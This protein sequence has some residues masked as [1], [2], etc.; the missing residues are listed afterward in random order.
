MNPKAILDIIEK[1]DRFLVACH[2][3]MEGDSLGSQLALASLLRKHGKQVITANGTAVPDSLKFLSGW[4][5]VII[6]PGT[7]DLAEVQCMVVVDCPHL[8]RIGP[9]YDALPPDV[10]I[11]N[12]DHH[13][14]NEQF[15]HVNWI[16]GCAAAVGEM[17]YDLF[18]ASGHPMDGD[19]ALAL[20][21][22]IMTDTGS[23]RFSNTT[24]G[25]LKR[26]AALLNYGIKPH[27]VYGHVYESHTQQ[28]LALLK[29]VLGNLQLT[30]NNQV[31]T[32]CV[33]LEMMER[34]GGRPESSDWFLDI[35]RSVGVV[36]A[37]ALLT[38]LDPGRIKISL[39]SKG[40]VDVNR[41]ACFFGGGGH[42]AAAGCT[43]EK[44]LAEAR[45]LLVEQIRRAVSEASPAEL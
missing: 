2:V 17:I 18:E 26:A 42:R 28:E 9:V 13:V 39:R 34:C 31:A 32:A 29:E 38:E 20:Y 8:K 33:T 37:T 11:V 30:D 27:E 10:F 22:S 6:D 4:P 25:T 36:R 7:T 1:Y 43:I 45:E 19:A 21:T 3:N 35:T 44:P 15:G 16:D 5:D 40:F 12:I 41:V 24:P 23:F 14:S